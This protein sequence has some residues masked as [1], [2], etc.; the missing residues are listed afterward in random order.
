[1]ASFAYK[2]QANNNLSLKELMHIDI[3]VGKNKLV[4]EHYLMR[5][6]WK[7]IIQFQG[8]TMQK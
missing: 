4:I 6:K 3:K 2:I 1:M 7:M 8:K 5:N